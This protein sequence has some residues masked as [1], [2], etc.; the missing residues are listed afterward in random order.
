MIALCMDP[1][2]LR[3]SQQVGG[4]N[5]VKGFGNFDP[6]TYLIDWL[7]CFQYYASQASVTSVLAS[8]DMEAYTPMTQAPVRPPKS[9]E[10]SESPGADE[11]GVVLSRL[12]D[13]DIWRS[14]IEDFVHRP[15]SDRLCEAKHKVRKVPKRGRKSGKSQEVRK[16]KKAP[17]SFI[18]YRIAFSD[19]AKVVANKQ[20]ETEYSKVCGKSWHR[21]DPE[22]KD[23]FIR[24]AEIERENHLQFIQSKGTDPLA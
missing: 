22:V 6:G 1:Q 2:D 18:L 13:E 14:R 7:D 21:E 23:W 12:V 17:N 15:L 8:D 20:A 3:M 24:Q 10:P 11:N 5:Y 16:E 4:M 9:E 19:K